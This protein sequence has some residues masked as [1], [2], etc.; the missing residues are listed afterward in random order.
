MTQGCVNNS[1]KH[2]FNQANKDHCR[3]A[4]KSQALCF[5]LPYQ[6]NDANGQQNTVNMTG[7]QGA[8]IFA[9]TL[10]WICPFGCFCMRL[11]S[12]S[13]LLDWVKQVTLPN[14]GGPV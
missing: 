3:V 14:V 4:H 8:Q 2:Q 5:F 9:Q 13:E 1:F 11:K 12:E 6:Q 7:P 10:F